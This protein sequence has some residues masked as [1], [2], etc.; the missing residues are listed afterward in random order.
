M[1]ILKNSVSMKSLGM[2]SRWLKGIRYPNI[3]KQ[4]GNAD[5][6]DFIF[7][8]EACSKTSEFA[9]KYVRNMFT[10]HPKNYKTMLLANII[11]EYLLVFELI[12]GYWARKVEQSLTGDDRAKE[13]IWIDIVERLIETYSYGF[14]II[15]GISQKIVEI[16]FRSSF[17]WEKYAKQMRYWMAKNPKYIEGIKKRCI[18]N[19]IYDPGTEIHYGEAREGTWSDEIGCSENQKDE[20]L[21]FVNGANPIQFGYKI[22]TDFLCKFFSIK[23]CEKIHDKLMQKAEELKRKRHREEYKNSDAL[24]NEWKEC[25]TEAIKFKPH[26]TKAALEL[27]KL[28]KIIEDRKALNKEEGELYKILLKSLQVIK[29]Q[30]GNNKTKEEHPFSDHLK[31]PESHYFRFFGY[32]KETRVIHERSMAIT[33]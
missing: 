4:K 11:S 18:P 27:L 8:T 3:R 14:S 17:D 19:D 28:L 30:S 9:Q 6:G 2:I 26:S 23:E 25:L 15:T 12:A 24:Y 29:K 13:K 1:P 21:G 7:F 10:Q 20:D 22:R 31:I 16:Y 5:E 32:G 33:P